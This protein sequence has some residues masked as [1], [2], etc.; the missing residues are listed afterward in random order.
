LLVGGVGAGKTA[1]LVR[2]TGLFAERHAVPVPLRL[3]DAAKG[4]NFREM[5]HTRFLA[6]AESSMLSADD[7]EKVC[8]FTGCPE[9][10]SAHGG[11]WR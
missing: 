1:V 11:Q 4:L 8:P 5:A 2:L 10:V 6:M 9:F 3:R 7:A